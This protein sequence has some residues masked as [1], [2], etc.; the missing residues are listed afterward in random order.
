MLR[1]RDHGR[2][3]HL[4]EQ[5]LFAIRAPRRFH[6]ERLMTVATQP[7]LLDAPPPPAEVPQ[8]SSVR[9]G[10]VLLRRAGVLLALAITF[11]LCLWMYTRHNDEP[12][13]FHPDEEGKAAQVM[14]GRYR[15]FKHPLLLLEAG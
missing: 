3:L 6:V 11:S 5:F 7:Q 15:N 4:P 9:L 14:S 2:R 13:W 12:S 1:R 10:A 8:E